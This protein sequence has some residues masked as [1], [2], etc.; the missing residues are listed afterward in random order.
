MAWWLTVP[1]GTIS[2]SDKP[3]PATGNWS[4]RARTQKD[5]NA[6]NRPPKQVGLSVLMRKVLQDPTPKHQYGHV[7]RPK[8]SAGAQHHGMP[9]VKCLAVDRVL[10]HVH[11]TREDVIG[12]WPTRGLRQHWRRRLRR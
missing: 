3:T 11:I 9:R 5:K 4:S 7:H 2:S 1:L 10:F 12:H 6:R 8:A